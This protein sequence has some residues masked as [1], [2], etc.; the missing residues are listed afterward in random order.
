MNVLLNNWILS[1]PAIWMSKANS[2]V[3]LT[4]EL[5]VFQQFLISHIFHQNQPKSGS[6]QHFRFI[7]NFHHTFSTRIKFNNDC[8]VV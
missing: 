8:D 1:I 4:A 2:Y 7:S 5:L 6:V 3:E